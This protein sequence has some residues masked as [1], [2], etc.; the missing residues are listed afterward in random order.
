MQLC[1]GP[2]IESMLEFFINTIFVFLEEVDYFEL[3]IQ[4]LI[5]FFH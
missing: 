1:N 2:S 4:Y 5:L 3:C